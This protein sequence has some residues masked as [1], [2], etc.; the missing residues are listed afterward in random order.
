MTNESYQD[1]VVRLQADLQKADAWRNNLQTAIQAVQKL[2]AAV[3][4]GSAVTFDEETS[5]FI[6]TDVDLEGTKNLGERVV[7]IAIAVGRPINALAV[8]EYLIDRGYSNAKARNLRPHIYNALKENPDFE[9]V[10]KGTFRYIPNSTGIS[11]EVTPG[12]CQG[13]ERML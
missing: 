8:A 3:G 1:I 6:G 13:A 4:D 2:D 9:K 11:Q 12:S 10:G 5:S 7:R